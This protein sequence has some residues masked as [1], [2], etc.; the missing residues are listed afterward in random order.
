V[1]AIPT[2][3]ISSCSKNRGIIIA[4]KLLFENRTVC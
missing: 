4:F 1:S 3:I 2:S